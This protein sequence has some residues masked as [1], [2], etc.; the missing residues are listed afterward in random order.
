MCRVKLTLACLNYLNSAQIKEANTLLSSRR[1][2]VQVCLRLASSAKA[3]RSQEEDVR[4][5]GSVVGLS[6]LALFVVMDEEDDIASVVF[7]DGFTHGSLGIGHDQPVWRLFKLKT[8]PQHGF[9]LIGL[10][11]KRSLMALVPLLRLF[12]GRSLQE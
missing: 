8:Q 2:P 11:V 3:G 4:S 1:V 10:L 9:L 5:G 6:D 7:V 12:E